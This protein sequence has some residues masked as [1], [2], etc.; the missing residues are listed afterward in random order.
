ME[1]LSSRTLSSDPEFERLA[2]CRQMIASDDELCSD[3]FQNS[4][5][6]RTW[7]NYIL[8]SYREYH[9]CSMYGIPFS[10]NPINSE[11]R[12]EAIIFIC[13]A[14]LSEG[15]KDAHHRKYVL[16]KLYQAMKLLRQKTRSIEAYE[17]IFPP[18]QLT[19]DILKN[20]YGFGHYA[21]KNASDFAQGI[22]DVAGKSSR[23]AMRILNGEIFFTVPD[24]LVLAFIDEETFRAYASC[25]EDRN[26]RTQM[27][28]E[29]KRVRSIP[30]ETLVM[31]IPQTCIKPQIKQIPVY[32]PDTE[33]RSITLTIPAWIGSLERAG[34]KTDFFNTTPQA[35]YQFREALSALRRSISGI[36]LLMEEKTYEYRK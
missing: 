12:Q 13:E 15:A 20:R 1:L 25:P 26:F 11:T 9:L 34:Q 29:L 22:D 31:K 14:I 16:G 19:Y 2:S 33:L 30:K 32:D 8:F 4:P 35:R 28:R 24:L 27:R 5:V 18:Y 6:I 36:E 7:H 17:Q 3:M 23:L 10:T 21:I